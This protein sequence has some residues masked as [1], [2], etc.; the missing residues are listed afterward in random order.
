MGAH[1]QAI[2][3]KRLGD[4]SDLLIAIFANRIGT[5]TETAQSG[6]AEEIRNHLAAGKPAMIYFSSADIPRR[7]FDAG[8][9]SLLEAFKREILEKRGLLG[10]FSDKR[11]LGDKVLVDLSMTINKNEYF[12]KELARPIAIPSNPASEDTTKQLIAKNFENRNDITVTAQIRVSPGAT[13]WRIKER[14]QLVIRMPRQFV[15]SEGIE[16]NYRFLSQDTKFRQLVMSKAL[17]ID[18]D[19]VLQRQVAYNY[20]LEDLQYFEGKI[21]EVKGTP[22]QLSDNCWVW[23]ITPKPAD[24]KATRQ[25]PASGPDPITAAMTK[26]F[27]EKKQ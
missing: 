7:S 22:H 26:A 4:P 20:S 27:F 10:E 25:T 9:I 21:D 24:E 14:M 23:D 16:W 17:E 13:P 18:S 12:K 3:N 6:T 2:I 19:E 1:A 15:E 5:P 11:E 8:Q